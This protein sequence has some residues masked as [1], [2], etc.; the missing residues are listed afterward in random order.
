VCGG[1]SSQVLRDEH[2]LKTSR[3]IRSNTVVHF[4]ESKR[5]TSTALPRNLVFPRASAVKG[6]GKSPAINLPGGNGVPGITAA[7]AGNG[8]GRIVQCHLTSTKGATS[9]SA[10]EPMEVRCLPVDNPFRPT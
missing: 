3:M 9:R 5:N 2:H 8:N 6:V 10:F 7:L 1:R 4:P